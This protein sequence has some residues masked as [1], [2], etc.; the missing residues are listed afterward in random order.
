MSNIALKGDVIQDLG[1]YLPNP[2][3]ESIE[4]RSVPAGSSTLISL[5]IFYSI[6]FLISDDYNIDDIQEQIAD[7]NF[8]C[9]LR[10]DDGVI[11]KKEL[12]S[13]I[14]S[15]GTVFSAVRELALGSEISS[16]LNDPAKYQDDLYDEQGRRILKVTSSKQIQFATENSDFSIYFY[17]FSSLMTKDDF[18]FL[19]GSNHPRYLNTSN[20][21]YEKL[22]SP[23]LNVLREEEVIYV[24]RQGE[25]YGQVP[26]LGLNRNFYKTETVAREDIISKVNALVRRFE[27]RSIGPLSDSVNS[28]KTVLAKEADTENLLVQ[29][30]KVRRSFPN[31]TNNNPVGNLYASFAKLLQNINSALAPADIVTKQRYLTGKVLDLRTGSSF[32]YEPPEP[33]EP[34]DTIDYI[35][36]GMFLVH[37]ERVSTDETSDYAV[38]KGVFFV[39]YEEMLKRESHIS[40]LINMDKLYEITS[41]QDLSNLRRILFSYFRIEKLF[42]FKNHK[43][44]A[45]QYRIKNYG[46]ARLNRQPVPTPSLELFPHSVEVVATSTIGLTQ[47]I[48][49]YNFG[50][51]NPDERLLCYEFQ[52]IDSYSALYEANEIE[53]HGSMQFDYVVI[54]HVGDYTKDFLTYLTNKFSEVN[55]ALQNY[56]SLAN[57]IC[58]YNN[59]D[60]RFNDFFV[61]SIREQYPSGNYPWETAPTLYTVMA[62]LLTGQFGTFE[63]AI[64]YSKNI[65]ATISPEN[66][67][68]DSLLN[69]SEAMEELRSEQIADLEFNIP[70]RHQLLI[71]RLDKEANLIPFNYAQL[72]RE[73][74]EE[75]AFLMDSSFVRVTDASTTTQE[76]LYYVDSQLFESPYTSK[77]TSQKFYQNLVQDIKNFINTSF[78]SDTISSLEA[79]FT[80]TMSSSTDVV[81]NSYDTLNLNSQKEKFINDYAKLI[82]SLLSAIIIVFRT[83]RNS[84]LIEK[85]LDYPFDSEIDELEPFVEIAFN[86]FK[87][88]WGELSLRVNEDFFGTLNEGEYRGRAT[89][90]YAEPVNAITLQNKIRNYYRDNSNKLMFDINAISMYFLAYDEVLENE[91]VER[92]L[93]LPD[94]II[95]KVVEYNGPDPS[96]IANF[97]DIS[98]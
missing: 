29:L 13:R 31:K 45:V 26:I 68:L 56:V 89:S 4:V 18:A 24:G 34:P 9:C 3:I 11:S 30:D 72:E 74:S 22:F 55:D 47:Y 7:V 27:G 50:F 83:K 90:I 46:N 53:N 36:E 98:L 95:S 35:P 8:F 77:I 63:D 75:M 37:R 69:F 10:D 71:H 49:E 62:Y 84:T 48:K 40:N 54:T 39:R 61:N 92:I 42:L 79:S 44:E 64:K 14:Y 82:D 81:L 76:G 12:L 96:E 32:S 16:F 38:N 85:G 59:I 57:E 51:Q 70:T 60:N 93:L 91:I 97:E 19:G 17:A 28:I 66:G 80:G 43:E 73:V 58:S 65:S 86:N 88:S 15:P 41:N 94:G 1:E 78:S 25:K 67:N 5:D 20:I 87:Q 33:R 21:A 52:D 2:Y 6:I 23:G